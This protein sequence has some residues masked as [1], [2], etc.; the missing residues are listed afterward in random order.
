MLHRLFGSFVA[1]TAGTA[2]RTARMGCAQHRRWTECTQSLAKA[3]GLVSPR[4]YILAVGANTYG[5]LQCEHLLA[6]V[7]RGVATHCTLVGGVILHLA[8][9]VT[10]FAQLLIA[11][12]FFLRTWNM[13][14]QLHP[15]VDKWQ[16]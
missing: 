11:I 3:N 12:A 10:L 8:L 1:L 4:F 15:L 16:V 7:C 13:S 2:V 6:G 9:H 5:A 14:P